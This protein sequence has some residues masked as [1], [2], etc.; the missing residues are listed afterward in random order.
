MKTSTKVIIK[1]QIF[2]TAVLVVVLFFVNILFFDLW[3][4]QYDE[5]ITRIAKQASSMQHAQ[6]RWWK[7]RTWQPIKDN[8]FF[9]YD[10]RYC[11]NNAEKFVSN[12]YKIDD[13]FFYVKNG[14]VSDITDFFFLQK[15]LTK[16]SF[17]ILLL[18]LILS[19]PIWT[20][21]LRTIYKKIFKA[22]KDL[23]E[24]NY[25]EVE[26]MNLTKNDE[27]K[28][29]FDTINKQIETISSFN[30]YVSHEIKTPLMN[31]SSSLDLMKI[32]Y[33]DENID[34]IKENIQQIK[35]I[36]DT[37]SK[38]ALLENKNFN[39]E[40]KKVN[41]CT[42]I[43]SLSN[44][45]KIDYS[46]DCEVEN[47]VTNKDLIQILISNLLINA[48]KYSKWKISIK[49]TKDYLEVLNPSW[50]I[51]NIDKLTDKFYKEWNNWLGLGLFLVKKIAKILGYKIEI[52]YDK[53]IFGVRIIF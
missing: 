31:I 38:L 44:D 12:I 9:M 14:V 11:L 40:K 6:G 28:I 23:E 10:T 45:L 36:L 13:K 1:F 52:S 27:F 15:I 51:K 20:L 4:K 42:F 30:K 16:S 39:V 50:E 22:V 47:I 41:I 3:I 33:N 37:L 29:L 21:F 17:L 46:M 19:Y 26:K 25:I 34:K 48:K 18:Y 43:K 53:G 5:K 35:S 49:I 2:T 24:K 32:K 7:F 8:C